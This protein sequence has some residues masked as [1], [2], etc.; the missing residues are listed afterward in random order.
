[1]VAALPAEALPI[2]SMQKLIDTATAEKDVAVAE[3]DAAVAEKDA[4]VAEKEAK[5]KQIAELEAMIR[6]YLDKRAAYEDTPP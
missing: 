6:R 2:E 4:A 5:D 1:M 3:K